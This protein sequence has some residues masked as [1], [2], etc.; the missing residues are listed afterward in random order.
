MIQ[1]LLTEKL[2]PKELNHMILPQRI[3]KSFEEVLSIKNQYSSSF[4]TSAYIMAMQKLSL[5]L[6]SKIK[7]AM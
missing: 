3:K 6:D 2:R 5:K 4:R 1:E 7:K